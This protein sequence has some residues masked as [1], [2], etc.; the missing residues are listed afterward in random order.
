MPC[1][2]ESIISLTTDLQYSIINQIDQSFSDSFEIKNEINQLFKNFTS[3]I[4][5]LIP[6]PQSYQQLITPLPTRFEK[7]KASSDIDSKIT[8]LLTGKQK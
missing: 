6:Y 7:S 3:K 2:K 4:L 5:L 8:P 1:L